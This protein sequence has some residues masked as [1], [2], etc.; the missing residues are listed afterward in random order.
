MKRLIMMSAAVL[1]MSGLALAQYGSQPQTSAPAQNKAPAAG[2]TA[3]AA[4]QTPPATGQ[5]QPQTS[6]PA[7]SQPQAKTQ[8]EYKAFM[9]AVQKPTPSDAE[10]AAREFE[11]K[12]PDS[13]LISL[14]FYQV[15]AQYQKADNAAK[16][17]EM[18]R[19]AIQHDPENTAALI[20]TGMVLS[21]RTRESDI[22]RDEKLAEAQ[23]DVTKALENAQQGK[24]RIAA[25]ATPE[26]TEA[27]KN[28][29]T[30]MA[31]AALGQIDLGKKNEAAAEQNLNKALAIPQGQQDAL[32]WLR[33]SLALDHQNKYPDAL[34]AANKAVDL[35]ASNPAVG[36]LA[37][38]EQSRLKQLT[39]AP[40]KP[41]QT[42]QPVSTTAPQTETVKPQ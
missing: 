32:T 38:I 34:N 10:Q 15:M 24:F 40:P 4:G 31:Y 5:A 20:L 18:G 42:S 33:L 11:V 2:Q 30:Y 16:T 29:V 14:L 22:D 41:A 8:E 25:S 36:N 37:K 13:E 17:I 23:K 27:F 1:I 39:A 28:T 35:S 9:T 7:N 3:P 21:E 12:Y 6:A 26:Q 19:K